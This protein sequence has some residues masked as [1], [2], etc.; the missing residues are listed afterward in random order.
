MLVFEKLDKRKNE[1]GKSNG[2]GGDYLG[3]P[4]LPITVPCRISNILF[5]Q[6]HPKHCTPSK[7]LR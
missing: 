6:G 5:S 7:I 3:D 4:Y 2:A 1:D